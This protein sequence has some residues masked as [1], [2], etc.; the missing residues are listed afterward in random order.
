M[1][2]SKTIVVSNLNK[3]YG[4]LRVA[5][6]VSF[7]SDHGEFLA[8]QGP[9]GS[10]KSTLLGLLAGLER[11]DS[12]SIS[13]DGAELVDMSEDS[14]ALFRRHHIGIVFQA[15]YLIPTLNVVENIALP[16]FPERLPRKDMLERASRV[17]DSVGLP[18]RVFG[19]YPGELSG[20]EQQR[21]AIA[22]SLIHD[23]GV[24]LADEPTGN[25]DSKSGGRVVELLCELNR[26]RGL[27]LVLVTHDDRVAAEA[28]RI[29]RIE[30]GR[31]TNGRN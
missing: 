9:S 21:V 13:I 20:G 23:P 6:E 25:L 16:L 30:D 17:A 4:Q 7:D 15:F 12:G 3:A 27:S 19:Q 14:L 29:L 26:Q 8:I 18:K 11:P 10:G 5:D 31:L 28:D 22:R 2:D 24:I 1:N